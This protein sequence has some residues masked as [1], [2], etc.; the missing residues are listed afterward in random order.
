ML[1]DIRASSLP[2]SQGH[3]FFEPQ[4]AQQS[5]VSVFLLARVLHDWAD[6]FCVKILKQLRATAGPKTQLVV[7]EQMMSHVCD[8]PVAHE[9]P[10]AELPVTPEPLLRNMGRAASGTYFTDI[11]VRELNLILGDKTKLDNYYYLD[12]PKMMSFLM[13]KSARSPL[14]VICSKRRV[15]GSMLYIMISRR[16]SGSKK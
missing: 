8:E 5:D 15:G 12:A 16:W 3:N 11:M 4:P 13:V 1:T 2:P 10:G 6:E 14:F 7:V 9:I